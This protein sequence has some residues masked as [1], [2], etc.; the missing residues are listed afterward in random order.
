MTEQQVKDTIGIENWLEFMRWM[1]GQ[2]VSVDEAGTVK[3]YDDDVM[4][5]TKDWPSK[6]ITAKSVAF[7]VH[8]PI[9]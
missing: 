6:I 9:P 3:Y 7:R 2:T 5:F 4:A 8:L 1:R